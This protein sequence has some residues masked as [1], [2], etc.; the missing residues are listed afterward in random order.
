MAE[1]E[2]R[3]SNTSVFMTRQRVDWGAQTV[4]LFFCLLVLTIFY[5]FCQRSTFLSVQHQTVVICVYASTL[6]VS[7]IITIN[8]IFSHYVPETTSTNS[9][10]QKEPADRNETCWVGLTSWDRCMMKVSTKVKTKTIRNQ[11]I[12]TRGRGKRQN[13][14]AN[15][16][17]TE[18]NRE[19]LHKQ[20]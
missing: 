16:G 13:Q 12:R 17:H 5:S 8:D 3:K 1:A 10:T 9:C 19:P 7:N 2:L 6:K 4:L 11:A 14:R 20:R 15:E 18:N